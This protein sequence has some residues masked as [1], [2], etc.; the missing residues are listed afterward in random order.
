MCAPTGPIQLCVVPLSGAAAE[1]LN[2]ASCGEYDSRL[3]ASNTPIVAPRNPIS[4]LIR[5]FSVISNR[6]TL[7]SWAGEGLAFTQ[8]ARAPSRVSCIEELA[9]NH[10]LFRP[11]STA[12]IPLPCQLANTFHSD[13]TL[14]R[15]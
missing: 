1:T 9:R 15:L 3:S 11:F 12:S 5:R 14:L 10:I 4:S 7:F 13:G 2:D 8:T 6:R